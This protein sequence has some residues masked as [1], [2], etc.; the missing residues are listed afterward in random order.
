MVKIEEKTVKWY[1]TLRAQTV[2]TEKSTV[3]RYGT[4][5]ENA[6]FST[7]FFNATPTVHIRYGNVSYSLDVLYDMI[8]VFIQ[9]FGYNFL[10][11]IPI[12]KRFSPVI[13]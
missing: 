12:Y 3:K 5:R 9:F 7:I 11:K 13:L 6:V 8:Y 1:A 10:L 2:K 4:V